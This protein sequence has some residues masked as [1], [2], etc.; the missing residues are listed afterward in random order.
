MSKVR[1]KNGCLTC[2]R[3]KKKCD[4]KLY[5]ECLNCQ[6]NLL[7]CTW[8][9]HVSENKSLQAGYSG[10]MGTENPLKEITTTEEENRSRRSKLA[11]SLQ[12]TVSLSDITPSMN[13]PVDSNPYRMTPVNQVHNDSHPRLSYGTASVP[14]S[15]SLDRVS[16][17]DHRRRNVI[18][19]RIAMQQDLV[20]DESDLEISFPGNDGR[21][22]DSES[23]RNR[24]AQQLDIA[25]YTL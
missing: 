11:D 13:P 16:K 1:S 3:K 22:V 4:E 19:E 15:R 12:T 9:V 8:P 21:K 20:D 10:Q 14:P 5:P 17:P 18:L 7:K 6:I 2:R 24:I 23:I 25:E